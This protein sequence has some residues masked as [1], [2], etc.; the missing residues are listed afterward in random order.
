LPTTPFAATDPSLLLNIDLRN[1]LPSGWIMTGSGIFDPSNGYL[2]GTGNTSGVANT[3]VP[4]FAS[5]AQMSS[6]TVAVRFQRTGVATDDSFG[7]NFW[8]STGNTVNATSQNRQLFQMRSN[9]EEC[10]DL[11]TA[12]TRPVLQCALRAN[13]VRPTAFGDRPVVF[14]HMHLDVLQ[15]LQ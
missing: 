1:G 5:S 15:G 10:D 7:S 9:S 13:D 6:G 14:D 8:D 2:P 4:V 11:D 12:P 3:D